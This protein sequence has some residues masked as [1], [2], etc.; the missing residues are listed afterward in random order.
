[1]R[2]LY[3]ITSELEA[4]NEELMSAGGE[5]TPELENK[6]AI[7]QAELSQK[8]TNYGL[9]I[10]NNEA[11]ITAIETEIKRLQALKT[12]LETANKK[13]KEAISNAMTTYGIEKVE[14]ATLKLSFRKSESVE[15]YD[16]AL[17]GQKFFSYKP[18]IDKT[19]IKKAIK[20]G[21]EVPGA[22]IV[23]NQNLQIK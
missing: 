10:L 19:E 8:A 15:V 2:A 20:D 3:H 4:I 22:R 6:L 21:E 23:T 12:P 1:M 7:T 11:D 5:V 9:V 14:S 17:L 13:L 18:T 16:E